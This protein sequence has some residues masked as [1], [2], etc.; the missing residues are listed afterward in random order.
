MSIHGG[1]S[2]LN[3]PLHFFHAHPVYLFHFVE[4]KL[5]IILFLLM[6]NTSNYSVYEYSI[7]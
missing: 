3:L 5:C 4:L 7:L 1:L 6:I 2:L